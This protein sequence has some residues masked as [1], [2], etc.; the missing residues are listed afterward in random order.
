MSLI[1]WWQLN[2]NANDSTINE[3]NATI[4]G[5][6]S[7]VNGKIG[8]ALQLN[9]TT[10]YASPDF[11]M[12]EKLSRVFS[13]S[14]WVNFN[15]MTGQQG[16]VTTQGHGNGWSIYLR[17]ASG[18]PQFSFIGY[19]DDTSTALRTT[20]SG[21]IS[22]GNWYNLIYVYNGEMLKG[23]VNGVEK[24]SSSL[25]GAFRTDYTALNIGY[26]S[27]VGSPNYM[28]GIID[29]VRLYDYALSVKEIKELSRAKIFHLKFEDDNFYDVSDYTHEPDSISAGVIR[30]TTQYKKDLSSCD[31]SS[32]TGINYGSNNILQWNLDCTICFWIYTYNYASPSR[33]NPFDKAYGGE[34]SIVLEND[35]RFSFYWGANGGNSAPYVNSSSNIIISSN[36]TWYHIAVVRNS[37]DSKAYWYVNGAY[38]SE[39][40]NWET[41]QKGSHDIIVGDGYVNPLNG[42][43][44]DLRVY[45]SCLTADDIKEIYQTKAS[46]DKKGNIWC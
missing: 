44:D 12:A 40:T 5:S 28:N 13:V 9:G 21:E 1:G 17:N 11:D 20:P 39:N 38:D 30:D 15:D 3:N 4:N 37:N 33:Q 46:L 42:L 27:S 41:Y 7:Y 6:P 14:V 8:Q 25:S 36:S 19:A 45:N 16:I 22:T 24:H 10:D 31:F 34:G 23:Y 29:D 26:D 18:G 35:G 32:G 43:L 2:G